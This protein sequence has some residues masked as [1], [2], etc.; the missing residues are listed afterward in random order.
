MIAK[1]H[2]NQYT[3]KGKKCL[4]CHILVDNRERGTGNKVRCNECQKINRRIRQNKY[5]KKYYLVKTRR[6]KNEKTY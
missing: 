5:N 2:S 6:I 4:D 3:E 1:I